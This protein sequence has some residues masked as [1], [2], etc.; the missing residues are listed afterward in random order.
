M[1]SLRVLLPRFFVG[2]MPFFWLAAQ[3]GWATG[4]VISKDKILCIKGRGDLFADFRVKLA[5][6]RIRMIGKMGGS[7]WRQEKPDT[8]EQYNNENKVFVVQPVATYLGDVNQG[9]QTIPIEEVEGPVNIQFMGR[10]AKRYLG[11]AKIPNQGRR[12]VAE[13]ICIDNNWL[14][15]VTHRMWC[16]YLGLNKFDLGLPVAV[17]QNRAKVIGVKNNVAQFGGLVRVA[18]LNCD[19]ISELPAN[20]ETF[21]LPVSWKCG[22]D[23]AAMMFSTN[24]ELKA[25]DLDDLFRS[26]L[27]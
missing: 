9:F 16:R 13:F 15:P 10:K 7:I 21:S 22:K 4:P 23:K 5:P 26:H 8:V 11:F 14:S 19:S 20:S 1:L 6:T 25:T 18:V 24:G 17:I 3:A 2:A 12:S 27:K